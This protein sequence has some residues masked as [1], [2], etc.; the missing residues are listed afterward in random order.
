MTNWTILLVPSSRRRAGSRMPQ[1]QNNL[2]HSPFCLCPYRQQPEEGMYSRPRLPDSSHFGKFLPQLRTCTQSH[3]CPVY[4]VCQWKYWPVSQ[5]ILQCSIPDRPNYFLFTS[6]CYSIP[7]IWRV[8]RMA[9]QC[10]DR[11]CHPEFCKQRPDY[12]HTQPKHQT[13]HHSSDITPIYK[14]NLPTP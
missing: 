14:G 10:V 13:T 6:S 9:F 4:A 1:S 5:I 7:G 12:Y 2:F 11:N 3:H 8:T